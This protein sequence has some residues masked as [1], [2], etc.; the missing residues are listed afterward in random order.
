M[1]IVITIDRF[2]SR[3]DFIIC[4][5]VIVS[6]IF[7]LFNTIRTKKLSSDFQ[8]WISFVLSSVSIIGGLDAIMTN[9]YLANTQNSIF[10]LNSVYS[11][12]GGIAVICLSIKNILV[13]LG[14]E[15]YF[16]I[17]ISKIVEP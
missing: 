8:H 11:C 7:V 16:S 14:F 6:F 15:R 12:I 3:T 2:I 1:E 17:D 5:V 13:L 10:N 9:I 4:W